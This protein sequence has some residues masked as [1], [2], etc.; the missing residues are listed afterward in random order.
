MVEEEG[1]HHVH[2]SEEVGDGLKENCIVVREK[3][4]SKVEV[5]LGFLQ[6]HHVYEVVLLIGRDKFPGELS[7][8]GQIDAQV[9]NLNC[10]INHLERETKTDQVKLVLTLKTVKEKLVRE[11]VQVGG[12]NLTTI[13]LEV[14]ARVLGKGK[15]TPMLREGIRCLETLPDLD[16]DTEASDWQGFD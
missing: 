10:R 13:N 7:L 6:V 1:H 2:F 8:Y 15:G 12:E 16:T 5:Q 14:V 9:P 11:K 4:G 3:Q